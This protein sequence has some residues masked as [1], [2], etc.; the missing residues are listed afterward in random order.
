MARGLQRLD[1][2]KMSSGETCAI[3]Y[4][5]NVPESS[6]GPSHAPCS[7]SS[8]LQML[9]DVDAYSPS[10]IQRGENTAHHLWSDTSH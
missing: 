2:G 1:L 5:V 8:Q 7:T 4:S 9:L 10:C 3:T 6:K